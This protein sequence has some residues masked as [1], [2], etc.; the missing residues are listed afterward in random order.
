MSSPYSTFEKAKEPT[1]W[2]VI[3]SLIVN[4]IMAVLT[5][6]LAIIAYCALQDN[7]ETTRS[8]IETFDSNMN[9]HFSMQR[10][11]AKQQKRPVLRLYDGPFYIGLQPINAESEIISEQAGFVAVVRVTN[12]GFGAAQN[13]SVEWQV[14]DVVTR[15]SKGKPSKKYQP[16]AEKVAIGNLVYGQVFST[17]SLP[18]VILRDINREVRIVRGKLRVSWCNVDGKE[19][20]ADWDFELTTDYFSE[21][22][23]VLLK[24]DAKNE[25]DLD[26]SI[27]G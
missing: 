3:T 27:F 14:S 20:D 8:Y 18:R 19:E 17:D 13:C 25:P 12:I 5:L 24:I 4:G 15:E 6:V 2:I 16:F 11:I 21:S 7:R 26:I 22:P 9:K 1:N 10:S 23:H